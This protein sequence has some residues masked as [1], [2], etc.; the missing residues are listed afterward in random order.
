MPLV[1]LDSSNANARKD[2]EANH[3]VAFESY[4]YLGWLASLSRKFY[5]GLSLGERRGNW[6]ESLKM[7]VKS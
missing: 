7:K 3:P 4:F 1:N 6:Y 5:D 2:S